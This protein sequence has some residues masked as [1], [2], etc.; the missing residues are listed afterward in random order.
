MQAFDED[1]GI[2][3]FP[4]AGRRARISLRVLAFALQTATLGPQEAIR[5]QQRRECAEMEAPDS[6]VPAPS[7]APFSECS[8]LQALALTSLKG[9]MCSP[10]IM[11]KESSSR[12]SAHILL[13]ELEGCKML[14]VTYCCYLS[15]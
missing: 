14:P 9:S 15:W 13:Q 10:R 12:L 6:S 5:R 1:P 2:S 3:C 8:C 11:P 4:R 7:K